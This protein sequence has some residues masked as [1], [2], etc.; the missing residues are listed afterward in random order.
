MSIT[1]KLSS[2]L[3]ERWRRTRI[4][5]AMSRLTRSV[6]APSLARDLNHA[7]VVVARDAALKGAQRND[8]HIVLVL[9]HRGLAFGFE[10]PDDF[11]GKLLQ[12]NPAA[13]RA[14]AGQTT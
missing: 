3:E 12:A 1:L 8:N 4:S 10:Q 14:S 5:R 11:A 9:P 6:E 2:W 7:D 13:D